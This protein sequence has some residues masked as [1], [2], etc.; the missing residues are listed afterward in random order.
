MQ[1]KKVLV[2]DGAWG[3]E[4]IEMGLSPGE[5]PEILNLKRASDVRRVAENYRNAGADIILTN[6]FGANRL[7]LKRAGFT[8]DVREINRIGVELSKEK[9]G[10]VLVFASVGPTGEFLQPLG[11]FKEEDFVEVFSEQVEG[12]IEGGTDG[13]IIETM[14]DVKEALCAL[15]A[16]KENSSLPVGISFSFN[17]G[18]DSFVTMMGVTVEVAVSALKRENPDIIGAN[19]GSVTIKDMVG[20]AGIMREVCNLPLWMKSNA[21]IPLMKNGRT[22]YPQTPEEMAETVPELIK[23][24]VGVIGGCCGTTPE[25]IRR[26]REKVDEEVRDE[27]R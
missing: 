13:V 23:A 12:F 24:G 14:S 1:E 18:K 26:I 10:E 9:A 2:A 4:F 3:T 22:F 15:R 11:D 5:I 19:C 16:V 27:D 25:H 6:T 21:G 20:I 8:G 17:K 7:K